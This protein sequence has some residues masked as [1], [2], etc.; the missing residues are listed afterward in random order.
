MQSKAVP[1]IVCVQSAG[2]WYS[3]PHLLSPVSL[4]NACTMVASLLLIMQPCAYLAWKSTFYSLSAIETW[5][6]QQRQ[7]GKS[8]PDWIGPLMSLLLLYVNQHCD[9]PSQTLLSGLFIGKSQSR[10]VQPSHAH[11]IQTA[12][13]E[14]TTSTKVYPVWVPLE[15]FFYFVISVPPHPCQVPPATVGISHEPL[16]TASY[17]WILSTVRISDARIAFQGAAG[18]AELCPVHPAVSP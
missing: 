6:T 9:A 1:F 17:I 15:K 3:P 5:G 10:I 2:F 16:G 4:T 18:R 7:P 11:I 13:S 12:D 8:F 14:K